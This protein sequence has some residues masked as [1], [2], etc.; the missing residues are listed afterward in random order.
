ML[1]AVQF[2]TYKTEKTPVLIHRH[3]L[4]YHRQHHLH[5]AVC[6]P[7]ISLACNTQQLPS[8]TRGAAWF[9]GLFPHPAARCRCRAG[10]WEQRPGDISPQVSRNT[11]QLL[12]A[13][14]PRTQGT[15][16]EKSAS[17]WHSA[18]RTAP[19]VYAQQQLFASRPSAPS[20]G[21]SSDELHPRTPKAK[22]EVC[23]SPSRSSKRPAGCKYRKERKYTSR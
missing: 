6:S 19:R 15:Q 1:R 8:A 10:H 17:G 4:V 14:R 23:V 20:P 7:A 3:C 12:Q 18:A 16:R 11:G 2:I 9:A 22:S 13:P 21:P 5:T